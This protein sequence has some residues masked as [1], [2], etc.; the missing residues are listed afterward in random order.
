MISCKDVRE[1][2]SDCWNYF[3]SRAVT[4]NFNGFRVLIA[5]LH[6]T[7]APTAI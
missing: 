1:S 5:L 7:P 3:I 6:K 4:A 2:A